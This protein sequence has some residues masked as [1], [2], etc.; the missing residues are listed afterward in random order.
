MTIESQNQL[1]KAEDR[2]ALRL[3]SEFKTRNQQQFPDPFDAYVFIDHITEGVVRSVRSNAGSSTSTGATTSILKCRVF[4]QNFYHAS[5]NNPLDAK[6]K[7]EYEASINQC[8]E[9]YIRVD[10]ADVQNLTNGSIWSCTI[11]DQTIQ[12][13]SL[14]QAAAFS[15]NP[16]EGRVVGGPSAAFASGSKRP[17]GTNPRTPG[18]AVEIKFKENR[19]SLINQSKAFPYK[20]FLPI[21]AKKLTDSGYSQSSI[22]ATSMFRGPTDQVN[23]MM[24]G[25]ISQGDS[26]SYNSFK[27]WSIKNYGYRPG[28]GAEVQ[29]I[30][31]EKDWSTDV[32][33]LKSKLISKVTEQY[34]A[35]RYISNHME[36]GAIDVRTNDML[37][38]DVQIVLAS[39]KELKAAGHVRKYQIENARADESS[40]PPSPEH[41]H[42]SLTSKGDPGE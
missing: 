9:G 28:Y 40:T 20:D 10:H 8:Q 13:I 38:S 24:G 31:A 35:G 15:F 12:L 2:L 27:A 3:E 36:S 1:L 18:S 32:A 29:T 33:G 16:S 22:V 14:V 11:K 26:Q 30:I 21:F 19:S 25:R 34:N 17:L 37:W 23:A 41:I 39:L 42:F 7:V 5:Q 4:D 6:S